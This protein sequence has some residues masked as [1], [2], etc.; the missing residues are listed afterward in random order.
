LKDNTPSGPQMAAI[1]LAGG[2]FAL[3][4]YLAA[5]HRERIAPFLPALISLMVVSGIAF[6]A[7]VYAFYL[8]PQYGSRSLPAL[9]LFLAGHMLMVLVLWRL[10]AL[11]G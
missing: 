4:G 1:L 8:R 9:F 6:L 11:G 5:N 2:A 10:G 3:C 7:A